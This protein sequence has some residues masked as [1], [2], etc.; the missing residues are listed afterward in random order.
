[1][2]F[3]QTLIFF[4]NRDDHVD[5]VGDEERNPDCGI[6]NQLK[7]Q[8]KGKMEAI[9]EAAAMRLRPILMTSLATMLGALPIAL[10]LVPVRRAGCRWVLW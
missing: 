1:L 10:A 4:T 9:L 5:W 6:A 7:E 3:N 2:V 8:G